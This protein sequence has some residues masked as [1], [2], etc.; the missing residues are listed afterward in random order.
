MVKK[1]ELI[2]IDG[3]SLIQQNIS[4]LQVEFSLQNIAAGTYIIR[5]SN[6]SGQISNSLFV[7]E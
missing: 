2:S 3:R 7:K 6:K 5:H 1:I 4:N